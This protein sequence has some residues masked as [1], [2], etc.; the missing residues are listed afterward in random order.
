MKRSGRY[1]RLLRSLSYYLVFFL[2]VA[3]VITCCTMLFVSTLSKSLDITF[4]DAHIATAAKL[5]F[6]NVVLLSLILSVFDRL[7]R[8]LMVERPSNVSMRRQI[9]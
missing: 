8:K 5:T 1:R 4:T 2:L 7:R 3:F 6:W 9:K